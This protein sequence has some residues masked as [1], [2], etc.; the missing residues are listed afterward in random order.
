VNWLIRHLPPLLFLAVM[1]EAIHSNGVDENLNI[2]TLLIWRS[3]VL[4][5]CC[6]TYVLTGTKYF[7]CHVGA[8]P[9]EAAGKEGD[10]WAGQG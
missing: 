7:D 4:V 5:S 10:G 9:D 3:F 8:V 1:D 6:V 2:W